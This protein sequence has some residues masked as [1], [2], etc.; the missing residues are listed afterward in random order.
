[1]CEWNKGRKICHER[2]MKSAKKIT[3]VQILD[4][5]G[6]IIPNLEVADRNKF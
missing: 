4:T 3:V 1:M 5:S 2:H 6:I